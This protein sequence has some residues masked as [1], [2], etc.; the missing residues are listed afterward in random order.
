MAHL[1]GEL[2]RWTYLVGAA[3]G[4]EWSHRGGSIQM[5]EGME[6]VDVDLWTGRAVDL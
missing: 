4:G 6:L 1:F 3:V 2:T 5:P